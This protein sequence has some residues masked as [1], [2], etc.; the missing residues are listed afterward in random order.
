MHDLVHPWDELLQ[1]LCL[2]GD[3]FIC[4]LLRQ[5]HDPL[6]PIAKA[7]GYLIILVLF[8][9]DLNRHVL[10]LPPI[11]QLWGTNLKSDRS[12]TENNLCNRIQL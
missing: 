6:Q 9:Q 5:R 10:L 3:D 12:N 11:S 1:D 8:L 2:F 7:R 4:N